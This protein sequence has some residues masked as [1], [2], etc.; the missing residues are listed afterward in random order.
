MDLVEK[1]RAC[2]LSCGNRNN[3]HERD[4]VREDNYL[5]IEQLQ[6]ALRWTHPKYIG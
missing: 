6:D 3:I 1:N 5:A 2:G 4:E